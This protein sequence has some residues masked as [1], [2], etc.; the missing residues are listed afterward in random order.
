MTTIRPASIGDIP[1][2]IR[3]EQEASTA[4]HW[5]REQYEQIFASGAPTRVALIGESVSGTIHGFVIARAVSP[6]WEIENI[7]VASHVQRQGLGTQLVRTL[8]EQAERS[9]AQS[10]WLEVRESNHPAR[11]VYRKLGFTESG[12][13]KRYYQNPEDNAVLY[14]IDFT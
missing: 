1:H 12:F 3:L 11:G 6:E 10:V 5:S 7:V 9:G 14:R 13:R 2:L 8:L 4:A